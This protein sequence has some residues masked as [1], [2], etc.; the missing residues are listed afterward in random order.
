MIPAGP[1]YEQFGTQGKVCQAIGALPGEQTIR[2]ENYIR[3]KF[4]FLPDHLWRNFGIL[5]AMMIIFCAVNLL[6]AEFIPS[7][8]SRG[9]ILI[10]PRKY[11]KS[12]VAADEE[13][14]V[15]VVFPK[16]LTVREKVE[17][18]HAAEESNAEIRKN[19]MSTIKHSSIFHWKSVNY[20][21]K[22]SEGNRR[23]L[24]DVAGYVKPGTLTALMVGYVNTVIACRQN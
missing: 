10:F 15:Q 5:I 6:A 1:S 14:S 11:K 23:I 3:V 24:S 19:R 2:G 4:D 17:K 18:D 13:K 20:D 16:D 7:Q 21:I 12:K 9:E 8:R 22:T